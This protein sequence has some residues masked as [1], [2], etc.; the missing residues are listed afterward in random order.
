MSSTSNGF[1]KFSTATAQYAGRP[2]TFVLAVAAIVLWG[3]VGPFTGYSEEWQLVVNTGTTI[4]TFL[5]VFILQNSQIRDSTALQ[6]KL[7]EL[8]L[9]SSAENRFVGIEKL[10]EAALLRISEILKAH[11]EGEEDLK[12]HKKLAQ[13]ARRRTKG[14]KSE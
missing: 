7:D 5:M 9:T 6:A 10:D 11:A 8:I 1:S 3:F 14:H 4:I 12:L 2:V 13:A